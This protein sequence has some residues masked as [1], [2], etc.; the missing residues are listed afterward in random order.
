M[1]NDIKRK[2]RPT[3]QRPKVWQ[4][5][6]VKK[7][8][9]TKTE[10]PQKKTAKF[11][12]PKIPKLKLPKIPLSQKIKKTKVTKKSFLF[13]M[14]V[15]ILATLSAAYYFSQNHQTIAG[16]N[17]GNT[18]YKATKLET[19]TPKYSTITPDKRKI[20]WTKIN[21][22]GSDTAI[23]AYVD[24]IGDVLISVTEQPLPDEF[25]T[26]TA[27]KVEK[28]AKNYDANTKLT[29]GDTTIYVGTSVKDSIQ[30][31]I[32]VKSNLLIMIKSKNIVSNQD[33]VNYVNSLK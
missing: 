12:L 13:V 4:D 17:K 28:L 33:W 2:K 19:G 16:K 9:I 25:K 29:A 5:I 14:V 26:K 15:V 24:K 7:P 23:Y 18:P 1:D 21:P 32:L 3:G 10:V 11:K 30:S 22:P 20:T 8:T 6:V 31:V 27:Y